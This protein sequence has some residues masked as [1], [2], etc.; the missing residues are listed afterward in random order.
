MNELQIIRS[1]LLPYFQPGVSRDIVDDLLVKNNVELK[2]PDEV[3]ELYQWRNGLIDDAISS[4]SSGEVQLFKLAV[5]TSVQFSIKNYQGPDLRD[6]GVSEKLFPLFDSLVGDFYLID[7]DKT[8]DTYKMIMYYSPSNPY[9]QDAVSIFDSLE[10]CLLTVGECYRQSAYYYP[11]GS[12]YFEINP[13]LEVS[14]WKKNNPNSEYF[15]ILAN[16]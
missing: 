13:K 5:F 14:I 9:F 8:S 2:L 15:K 10:S 1:P 6:W 3:Y 4:K 12:P 11:S 7:T 16:S